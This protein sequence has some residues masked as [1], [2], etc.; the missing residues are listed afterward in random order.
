MTDSGKTDQDNLKK[1]MSGP[2]NA[3]GNTQTDPEQPL[4]IMCLLALA[5]GIIGGVGAWVFRQLIGIVHN[6]LFLGQID[7]YYDA[8]AHTSAQPLDRLC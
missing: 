1:N 2:S 7:F 3:I 8:N 4:L 6:T 5:T